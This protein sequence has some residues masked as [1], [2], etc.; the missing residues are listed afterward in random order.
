MDN[1]A[2]RVL[3]VGN[4]I[5]RHSPKS[6]IGWAHDFGMAASTI[7]NDYVHLFMRMLKCV[8]PSAE[9]RIAQCGR[10]EMNYT[11]GS[12]ILES[13]REYT[14]PKND[15]VILRIGENVPTDGM[16]PEV[17][18]DSY[19]EM[20]EFFRNG[21]AQIIITDLFWPNK[22]KDNV[23]R[24]AARRLNCPL[25]NM[26][27]LGQRDEMMALGLFEHPGVQAHPGDRGMRAIA[28]RIFERAMSL[29]WGQV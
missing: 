16:K 9:H 28:F 7:E 1:R 21:S 13:Y 27:D 8:I 26:N 17:F 10:W 4:S 23:I 5:T 11:N 3:F 2:Y 15:L 12:E 20:A 29:I 22:V 25:V 18:L 6:D 14:E 24:E 19:M